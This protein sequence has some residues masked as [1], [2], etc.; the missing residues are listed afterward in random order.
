MSRGR[1]PQ[2]WMGYLKLRALLQTL[3]LGRLPM[4]LL[5]A[6]GAFLG[7]LRMGLMPRARRRARIHIARAFPDLPATG[8]RGIARASAAH[9]GSAWAEWLRLHRLSLEDRMERYGLSA[10]EAP[11]R[12]ALQARKGILVVTACLGHWEGLAAA[13]GAATGDT[14]LVCRRPPSLQFSYLDRVRRRLAVHSCSY[15]SARV[16]AARWLR[17][18]RVV[19]I[20][21]D[22]D[23]GRDGVFLPFFGTQASVLDLSVQLAADTGAPCVAA[24]CLREGQGYRLQVQALDVPPG[25]SPEIQRERLARW[26]VLLEDAVRRHP[27]QYAWERR[28]WRT[29]PARV[30]GPGQEM[31]T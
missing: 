9:R 7:R 19:V 29:R 13:L 27:G 23:A 3:Q 22:E 5:R 17:L 12:E 16:D 8:Q 20:V 14:L 25:A 30:P 18:N 31:T 21:T 4:P 2:T 6:L 24:L 28:R 26:T 1:P 11:V 10:L 15:S